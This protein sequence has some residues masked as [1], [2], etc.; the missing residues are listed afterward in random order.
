MQHT[1]SG[2]TETGR[3]RHRNAG[4]YE[5]MPGS[6][7]LFTLT[8]VGVHTSPHLPTCFT[9]VTV[10]GHLARVR[11]KP[12]GKPGGQK[13]GSAGLTLLTALPYKILN[14]SRSPN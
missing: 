10:V 3:Q 1:G 5:R 11:L 12:G 13:A 9:L 4:G 14:G 2:G 8:R 6:L 7:R